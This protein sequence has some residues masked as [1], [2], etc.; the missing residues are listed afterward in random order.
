M[1]SSKLQHVLRNWVCSVF[2]GVSKGC[3]KGKDEAG[4][5]PG[6]HPYLPP[7][8][9]AVLGRGPGAVLRPPT[10]P[11]CP[12]LPGR[13]DSR[14]TWSPVQR[15]LQLNLSCPHQGREHL[16]LAVLGAN[17][18]FIKTDFLKRKRGR[19][20]GRSPNQN[21]ELKYEISGRLEKTK[22]AAGGVG[23]YPVDVGD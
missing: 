21:I 9:R 20:E 22:T 6:P 11:Y 19:K 18:H 8:G 12:L 14:K 10:V 7:E 23:C 2:L 5:S 16:R 17:E 13:V 3:P 4:S 1:L 15:Q